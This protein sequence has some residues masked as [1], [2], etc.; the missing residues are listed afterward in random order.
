MSGYQ[1]RSGGKQRLELEYYFSQVPFCVM[2]SSLCDGFVLWGPVLHLPIVIKNRMH[3]SFKHFQISSLNTAV[4]SRS[5]SLC[6]NEM[7][8]D[9]MNFFLV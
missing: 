1:R 6:G 8:S 9:K 2:T 7:L 4:I 5:C 3:N